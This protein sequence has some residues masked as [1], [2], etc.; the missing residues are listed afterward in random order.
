MSSLAGSVVVITGAGSGIGRASAL[1]FAR[2]GCALHLADVDVA[3]VES[4][5]AEAERLGARARAHVVDV[6]VA[7]QME[8]LAEAAFAQD[9]RVDVLFLNAGIGH[10][11]EIEDTTLEDWQRV[12][13]VNLMGVVHGVTAFVPRLL[14]QGRP[15]SVIA[16]ASV[17]GLVATPKQAP[18]VA[19]KFAVVGICE[20]LDAELA[21]R[22]IRFTAV[23]PGFIDT[24]IVADART[25]GSL[26][27]RHQVAVDFYRRHGAKPETVAKTVLAAARNGGGV[28]TVPRL[29]VVP[30]WGLKRVSLRLVRPLTQ[31]LP[32]LILRRG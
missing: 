27:E 12:L 20:S 14:A 24:S 6:S 30:L 5:R 29:H 25:S 23:C 4:V 21:P 17:L 13:D 9:G 7:A 28:R 8:G 10:G 2:E 32:D 26:R 18:Y 31:R 11:G 19:S 1:A 3:R 22:G 15:A 16:T